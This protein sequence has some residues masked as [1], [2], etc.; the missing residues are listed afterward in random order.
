MNNNSKIS[1]FILII[2]FLLAL[3]LSSCARETSP[4]PQAW[5]DYPHEGDVI[6]SGTYVT[7]HSHGFAR[8]G[9]AE[10]VLSV[11]GEAYRYDVPAGAG[12]DFL[13]MRQDWIPVEAGIYTLQVQVYDTQGQI[14]NPAMVTVKVKGTE[15]TPVET[16]S[17]PVGTVTPVAT[18]TSPPST[19]PP[20]TSPPPTEPPA[21]T[22]PPPVP[23]PAVPANGLALSCRSSQT[24]AWL[25]VT[26]PSGIAG[27]YV[28]LELEIKQG[29][30]Q[31][32]GG[33][34]PV[35]GKQV[36]VNVQCGGVYRWMV[37]A[38]DG[39][40]NYSGWSAPSHFSINLD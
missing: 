36:D 35:T 15:P 24:L 20:P 8:E 18:A 38:Q 4:Y 32:A 10:I 22:T 9:V 33:Y 29:Q 17:T 14:S 30:W 37:R 40:G 3:G 31:S 2:G 16:D 19:S 23:S 27:Y 21:D 6:P 26:D 1:R 34:G 28:K 5:I 11:N 13:S 25:P 12:D 7:V 39:A